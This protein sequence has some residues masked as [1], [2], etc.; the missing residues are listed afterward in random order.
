LSTT[1]RRP[2]Y[3][4]KLKIG[5]IISTHAARCREYDQQLYRR[6]DYRPLQGVSTAETLGFG[7]AFK[8]FNTIV[9]RLE[10]M[11]VMPGGIAADDLS[12]RRFLNEAEI[13]RRLEHPNIVKSYDVVEIDG[14]LILTMEFNE[15]TSLVDRARRLRILMAAQD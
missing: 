1:L 13:L 8:V 5:A 3:C 14:D 7:E 10:I 2:P 9:G 4:W 15:G 6:Q 11:R 12:A